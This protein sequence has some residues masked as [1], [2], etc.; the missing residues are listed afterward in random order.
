MLSTIKK[1]LGEKNSQVYLA[2]LELG[3]ATIAQ[4]AKKAGLP[5]S[6]TYLIID[7]LEEKGLISK[8]NIG[9][10]SYIVAE[11]PENFQKLLTS[12]QGTIKEVEKE[13]A[14][15]LPEFQA[16]YKGTT[17]KAKIRY[18]EGF[19]AMKNLLLQVLDE[20]KDKEYL[21]ICQGYTD[22]EAGL[23]RD[24]EYIQQYLNKKRQQKVRSREIIEDMKSAREYQDEF[25][26]EEMQIF[27]SPQI[28]HKDTAHIDKYIWGDKVCIF[29]NQKDYAV[30]I[31]DHHFAEN[32]RISFNVLWNALKKGVYEYGEKASK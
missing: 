18:Y 8:T 2:S 26:C 15:K 20:C 16:L 5:R 23:S 32:E 31:E 24:P 30:L 6:S 27:L 3:T 13:F 9:S 22:K 12:Q 7:E 4:I 25:N 11:P 21:N 10:K 28:K 1:I 14:E 17:Q 29:N 19:E